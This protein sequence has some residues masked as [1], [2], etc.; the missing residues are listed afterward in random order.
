MNG[1]LDKHAPFKKVSKYQLTLKT[2]P[3]ITAAI[4]KIILVKNSSFK[5]YIELKDPV[6]EIETHDKYKHWRNLL[7]LESRKVKK[8]IMMNSLLLN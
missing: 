6:K 2:K 7:Q 4:H 3:W 1:L 5:E 8:L